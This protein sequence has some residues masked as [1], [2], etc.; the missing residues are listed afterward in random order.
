MAWGKSIT[1]FGVC[2]NFKFEC[3][4][5]TDVKATRS[6]VR[7]RIMSQIHF[8]ASTNESDNAD[9]LNAKTLTVDLP[10]IKFSLY[11]SFSG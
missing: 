7:P 5:L 9:I 10:P 11:F 4:T 3:H 6:L 2:G 1:K 8:V